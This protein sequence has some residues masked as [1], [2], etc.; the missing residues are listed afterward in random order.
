M[1]G[2]YGVFSILICPQCQQSVQTKEG[3]TKYLAVVLLFFVLRVKCSH[4]TQGHNV[5]SS[6]MQN[7]ARLQ[8]CKNDCKEVIVCSTKAV[9][10]I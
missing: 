10:T 4:S 5:I 2:I 1:F 8:L 9:I 7:T 6:Q 3:R